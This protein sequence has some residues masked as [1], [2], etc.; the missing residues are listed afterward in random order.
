MDESEIRTTEEEPLEEPN[1]GKWTKGLIAGVSLTLGLS[2]GIVGMGSWAGGVSAQV[3][4]HIDNPMIHQLPEQKE[5][6]VRI[7][8][9]REISPT[10]I[11][12][13]HQLDRIEEKVER[14]N[15]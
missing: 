6:Q 10:L 2:V 14:G 11:R 13:Q 4:S 15:R 3:Q 5:A 12:M 8:L 7:I 9:D 1:G